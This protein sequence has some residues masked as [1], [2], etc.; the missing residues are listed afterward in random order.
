MTGTLIDFIYR[1]AAITI[2]ILMILSFSCGI[3]QV[4]HAFD[5]FVFVNVIEIKLV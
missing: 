1:W 3:R 2:M 5:H 4:P